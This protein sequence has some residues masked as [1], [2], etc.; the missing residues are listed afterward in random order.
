[1]TNAHL[2]NAPLGGPHLIYF[3]DPM[4]AWCWG[5][6][7]VIGAIAQHYGAALPIRLILGGLRPYTTEPMD[8]GTVEQRRSGWQRVAEAS[9][10]PFDIRFWDRVGF[11][12]DTE[13]A[14]RAAAVLRRRSPA[15]ALDA[16]RRLHAAFYAEN[17]DV[18]QPEV[19]ADI[20][21]EM[22]VE[23]TGFLAELA[24]ESARAETRQDFAIS[25]R[26]GIRGFPSLIAGSGADNQY[27]MLTNGFQPAARVLEIVA[28]WQASLA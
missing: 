22:G 3:A 16:L 5:F 8:A 25:Q 9:G 7:P 24:S 6:S 2:A 13:P 20:A 23:R 18:T 1:M 14:S 28:A 10:Q 4:C 12:Y 26:T 21:E 19:L 11:V 27:V 15:M 17:R